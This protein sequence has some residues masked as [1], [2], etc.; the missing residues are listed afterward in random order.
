[1]ISVVRFPPLTV[2]IV[3]LQSTVFV[4]LTMVIMPL[5]AVRSKAIIAGTRGHVAPRRSTI[6]LRALVVQVVLF[7]ISYIVA[8][9]H[10]MPI[11]TWTGLHVANLLVA[12]GSLALLLAAGSLS[13]HLR[14]PEERRALWMK[15][16][17]PVTTAQWALWMLLSLAAGVAEETAY[18]GVL[19][20]I[21]SSLTASF[22]VGALLSAAA[23]AVVHY[24]QGAKS[25]GWVFVL[26]LVMQAVVGATGTLYV[27]MGVHAV[28]DVTAAF[29]AVNW[30]RTE[31]DEG[32][33][34]AAREAQTA[35]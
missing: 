4:L 16:L 22:L 30:M 35:V 23:F 31:E 3:D 12:A 1:M 20:V 15:H 29:R 25:M 34:D 21:L 17:L 8:R 33:R 11:W 32:A 9:A 6:L 10:D 13:W 19:V 5:A 24:P 2:R 14:T 18:R 7:A 28:Y 26:G 27:A